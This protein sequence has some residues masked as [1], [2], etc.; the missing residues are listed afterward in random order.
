MSEEVLLLYKDSLAAGR[1]LNERV[2]NCLII[3]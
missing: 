1:V 3:V 2:L